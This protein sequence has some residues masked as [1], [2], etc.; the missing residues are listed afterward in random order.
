MPRALTSWVGVEAGEATFMTR[1]VITSIVAGKISAKA[2]PKLTPRRIERPTSVAR[3]GVLRDRSES[4]GSIGAFASGSMGWIVA[5][6]R[7]L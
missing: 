7:R 6:V 5:D 1:P 3:L 4:R 2:T